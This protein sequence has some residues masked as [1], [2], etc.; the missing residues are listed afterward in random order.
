M[1]VMHEAYMQAALDEAHRASAQHEVPIGAVVVVDGKVVGTGFNQPISTSDPTAHAEVVALRASART[2]G[3]YRITGGTLY[4][5]VEPCLMCV[6]AIIH[7]RL[8][9]VVYG[10]AEPKTGAVQSTMHAFDQKTLNHR[11]TVVS[12]VLEE[13]CA[14]LLQ[15]FFRERRNKHVATG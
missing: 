10:A 4:V 13:E 6:G 14:E 15:K 7:A 1:I 3:N 12:G 2:I 8:G 9:K 11:V 5:T